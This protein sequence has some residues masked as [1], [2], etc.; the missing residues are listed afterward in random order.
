MDCS[1]DLIFATRRR[2]A[3]LLFLK[4][5]F[6]PLKQDLKFNAAREKFFGQPAEKNNGREKKKVSVLIHHSEKE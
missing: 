4:K 6:V 5:K 1:E 3:D 2:D